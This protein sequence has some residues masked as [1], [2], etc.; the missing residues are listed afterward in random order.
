VT[1]RTKFQSRCPVAT[2]RLLGW[3]V[4]GLSL[5]ATADQLAGAEKS[6]DLSDQGAAWYASYQHDSR[7]I[8]IPNGRSL[9]VYC[10]GKGSPT[11]VLEPGIGSS[12]FGL[13]MLQGKIAKLTRVCAYDRAGMGK[14]PPGPLPRDTA[15]EVADLEV[16]LPAADI[17]A[18]YIL[19]GHSMGGFNAR[20]LASVRT[21]DVAGMVLIDPSVENQIPILEA[22]APA[23]AKNDKRFVGLIRHCANPGLP[24][25]DFNAD[26][27]RSPP[28]TFPPGLAAAYLASQTR[29]YFKARLS[30]LEAF[31]DLDSQEVI[32]FRH[33][34]GAMPLIV[35]TRGMPSS[36]LP[37]EQAEI[38][39]KFL[40]KSHDE[41]AALST[42]GTNRVV[43]GASHDIQ[44][45]KPDAVLDAI[46]EVLRAVRRTGGA[47]RTK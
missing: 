2:Y 42:V 7:L 40:K 1:Q 34:F 25:K 36:D 20:R 38:E 46:G 43:P 8:Q 44:V 37:P 39:L 33:S 19:V 30:E 28:L 27:R 31:F 17:R 29:T 11:V 13:W 9:N 3:A 21:K 10:L 6:N 24:D 22:A 15:A 32:A 5:L 26:C 23:I 14:S 45:D 16:L 35:L 41:I 18:P 47:A 4:V 12:A